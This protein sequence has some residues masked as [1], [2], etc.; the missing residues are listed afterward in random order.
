MIHD[1]GHGYV[2]DRRDD[3]IADRPSLGPLPVAELREEVRGLIRA[4]LKIHP[5]EQQAI[6]DEGCDGNHF[7]VMLG[8]V[9]KRYIEAH[10][11]TEDDLKFIRPDIRKITRDTVVITHE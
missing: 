7:R 5:N 11:I 4:Y 3:G 6:A 9:C 1:E 8:W 10:K 2:G